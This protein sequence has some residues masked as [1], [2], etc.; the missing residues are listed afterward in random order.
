[1][2]SKQFIVRVKAQV[3]RA[4]MTTELRAIRRKLL[5]K[6]NGQG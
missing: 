2:S 5:R 1:M 6:M 4:E 3:R